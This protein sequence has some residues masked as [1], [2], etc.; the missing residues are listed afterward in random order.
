M[1]KLFAALPL[2]GILCWQAPAFADV[3]VE[4]ILVNQAAPTAECTNIRVNLNND[5]PDGRHISRVDLQARENSSSE[6]KTVKTWDR[7]NM[8]M[9]AR[10][11]L[12]LD[13]L[14]LADQH[15]D[16][17][18]A[19]DHYELRALVTDRTGEQASEVSSFERGAL[20]AAGR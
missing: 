5:G 20:T 1:N 2:L 18:L 12:S 3:R 4:Q 11:R 6:W 9:E 17:T 10:N 14:P 19:A 7:P 8:R 15:L 13:F 16:S